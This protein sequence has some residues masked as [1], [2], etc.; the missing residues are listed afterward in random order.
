[1]VFS[2]IPCNAF[3]LALEQIWLPL[4]VIERLQMLFENVPN[5]FQGLETHNLQEKFYRDHLELVVSLG[6]VQSMHVVRRE[7]LLKINWIIQYIIAN[8]LV[9]IVFR[10]TI[11][12]RHIPISI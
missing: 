5:P 1:M 8:V 4:D 11:E 6:F 10:T 3:T 12:C 2:H 7:V 9:C